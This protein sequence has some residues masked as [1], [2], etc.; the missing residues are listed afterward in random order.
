MRASVSQV[1]GRMPWPA[2]SRKRSRVTV[3]GIPRSCTSRPPSGDFAIV[4]ADG[5]APEG[6]SAEGY[7]VTVTAEGVRVGADTDA[8]AFLGVQTV[9]QLIPICVRVRPAVDPGRDHPRLSALRLPG[10]DARRRAPLLHRRRGRTVH[11][12]DRP[13]QVQ[14]PA[15]APHRRPGLAHRTSRLA[16]TSPRHGGSHRQ[17]RL[18]WRL[19][20]PRRLPPTRRVRGA[21]AT[22]RSCPRSTCRGTRTRRSPRIRD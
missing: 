13:A 10:R 15:P 16:A 9:R 6:H 1:S 19:L 8:G 2:H 5:E 7:T 12:R 4:I 3:A 20:H 18:A 21:R 11:R 14:P 17:R 22:S